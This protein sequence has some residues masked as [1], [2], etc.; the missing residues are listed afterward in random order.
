MSYLN[1]SFQKSMYCGRTYIANGCIVQSAIY[2]FFIYL[3]LQKIGIYWPGQS[4]TYH[5]I[6][7]PETRAY[8]MPFYDIFLQFFLFS[9]VIDY[10][11]WMKICPFLV[12]II[13]WQQPAIMVAHDPWSFRVIM[14][15]KVCW[16]GIEIHFLFF[17]FL[18]VGKVLKCIGPWSLL[19]VTC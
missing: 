11:L 10:K 15:K 14:L 19:V 2:F 16:L 6:F 17:P 5:A 9:A 4:S 13:L 7:D 12:K 18:L 1:W 3:L 8:N